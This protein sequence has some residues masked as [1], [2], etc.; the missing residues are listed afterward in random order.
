M[1][2]CFVVHFCNLYEPP[3]PNTHLYF[4]QSC[5]KIK[6]YYLKM[7][8]KHF[9]LM[10]TSP[11]SLLVA[12]PSLLARCVCFLIRPRKKNHITQCFHSKPT[13]HFIIKQFNIKF[14]G[15]RKSQNISCKIISML[16]RLLGLDYI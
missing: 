10:R 13:V 6:A 14:T 15:F 8:A 3:P 5:N 12:F 1:C 2:F 11:S 16:L 7:N 4:C 9:Y